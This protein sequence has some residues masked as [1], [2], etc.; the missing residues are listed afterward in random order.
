MLGNGRGEG[1]IPK[2]QV[3]VSIDQHCMT[4]T[5]DTAADARCVHTLTPGDLFSVTYIGRNQKGNGN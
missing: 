4:L 5:L 3:S 1:S 2:R